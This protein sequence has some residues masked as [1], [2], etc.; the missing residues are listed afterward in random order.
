VVLGR[1]VAHELF[2]NQNPVGKPV[3]VGGWRMRVIGVLASRGQQMGMDM[4]D[5]VVI[6]VAT[7]LQMSNRRS[8]MRVMLQVLPQVDLERTK[9]RVID[10]ISERHGEEDI[11]CI[12][13]EAVL[14]GLSKILVV[15]TAVVVSIAGISLTVAGIGIMNV[16][17]VSVS[18][19]TAEVGLMKAL[20]ATRRQILGVFLVEAVLLSS[21]GGALGL[22]LGW[23]LIEGVVIVYPS[24]PATP[25]VWAVISVLAV[26]LATGTIFGVLP[27][28]RAAKL[29]PVE[30]LATK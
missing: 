10:L 23:L 26:S 21:T 30:A 17:L 2:D 25:P 8:L 22:V 20:G 3:R 4:D 24:L 11:S 13:Q 5:A 1:K 9:Q 7:G 14:A 19:R 29:D 6:P 15:L 18:E 16:M 12:T 27:A 28:W